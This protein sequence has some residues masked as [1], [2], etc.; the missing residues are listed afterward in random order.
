[1][2]LTP[3]GAVFGHIYYSQQQFAPP[4]PPPF[5]ISIPP[6]IVLVYGLLPVTVVTGF[7]YNIMVWRPHPFLTRKGVVPICARDLD[8]LAGLSLTVVE[9]LKHKIMGRR[10]KSSC[11]K[12]YQSW[13]RNRQKLA[14][15]RGVVTSGSYHCELT[16]LWIC[17]DQIL[18]LLTSTSKEKISTVFP[19][20]TSTVKLHSPQLRKLTETQKQDSVTT[21]GQLPVV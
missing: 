7:V 20:T 14:G 19:H 17:Q 8:W 16:R 15:D 5:S 1:M 6:P 13:Y 10:R 12:R 4:P 11:Y 18:H 9:P 21:T 3:W 2:P